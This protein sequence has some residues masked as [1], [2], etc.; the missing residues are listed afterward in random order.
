MKQLRVYFHGLDTDEPVLLGRL[1]YGRGQRYTHFEM[2]SAFLR[3]GIN[4]SPL[5]L[6]TRTGL[7]PAPPNPFDGLH[8]LFNDSLPDGWGRYLMDRAFR[9]RGLDPDAVTPLHRLASVGA[10]AM[11][12]LSYEPDDGGADP[13]VK[14]LDIPTIGLAATRQYLGDASEL[15]DSLVRH[16]SPSG[17]ARPKILIGI[18]DTDGSAVTGADDLPYGH[19][20]WLAKFP[21]GTSATD[22]SAG[23]IEYL[24]SRM[25]RAAGIHM[26]ETRLIP[27]N[28]GNAYFVTRRFDR[29]SGNRRRHIH[30]VAGLVHSDFRTPDFDYLELLK[31]SD[32]LTRSHAEKTELFRR[33]VFNIVGGNRDD[34][35]RNFAFEM[36]PVGEWVSTPAYDLTYNPGLAGHHSMTIQGKGRDFVRDDLLKLAHTASIPRAAA[37]RIIDE[38]SDAFPAWSK[39]APSYPIPKERTGDI[40]RHIDRQRARLQPV[41]A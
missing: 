11:G 41:S 24:Y 12:A 29:R 16:A 34:H 39:E 22:R 14:P 9:Q 25:A 1:G 28:K 18:N 40:Q 10:R 6:E 17:G 13:H 23:A 27:G 38:V 33:M 8:G 19:S 15:L 5:R 32:W 2:D 37:L 4:P 31:L 21:T 36:K 20:H 7:Q 30:S 35:T 26:A 3:L